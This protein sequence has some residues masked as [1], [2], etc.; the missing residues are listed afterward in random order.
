MALAYSFHISNKGHALTTVKKVAAVSKH[1]LRKYKSKDYDRDQIE[2]LRG[3]STNILDDV[4]AVYHQEFD[5]AVQNYNAK[6][7]RSDRKIDNYLRTVSDNAKNDVAV[8]VILQIGDMEFWKDKTAEE[9]KQMI[10]VF[11]NQIREMEQLVPAFR[12]ANATVHLDEASPHMHV[13]GIPVATGYKRGLERQVSKTTV[14]T[15]ES[16]TMLQD[17]MRASAEKE[18]Q[19]L[20]VFS[21]QQIQDKQKGRNADWSKEYYALQDDLKNMRL[22]SDYLRKE[23]KELVE[24]NKTLAKEQKTLKTQNTALKEEIGDLQKVQVFL[25]KFVDQYYK[26]PEPATP[27]ESDPIKLLMNR[28]AS[29]SRIAALPG[30]SQKETQTLCNTAISL[31]ELLKDDRKK[32]DLEQE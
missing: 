18:M 28:T 12:I 14:F 32:E 31:L 9:K 25:Q 29:R 27:D 11:R 22:E 20:P 1:N 16:L 24:T 8:E 5:P 2:V 26:E 21:G 6:Q 23:Q 30:L 4:E 17:K 19:E 7:K 13:V 10:P 3:S 15:R